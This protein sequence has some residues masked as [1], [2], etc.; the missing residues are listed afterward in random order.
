[1][2][3]IC[4]SIPVFSGSSLSSTGASEPRVHIRAARYCCG[5]HTVTWLA[6]KREKPA[7]LAICNSADAPPTGALGWKNYRKRGWIYTNS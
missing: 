7:K 4:T 2:P 3:G 5:N 6:E 1:M